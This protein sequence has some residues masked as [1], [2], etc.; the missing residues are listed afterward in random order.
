MPTQPSRSQTMPS[1]PTNPRTRRCP[2]SRRRRSAD[3]LRTIVELDLERAR[4][5]AEQAELPVLPSR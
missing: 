2:G 5:V 4:V 3:T 1:P